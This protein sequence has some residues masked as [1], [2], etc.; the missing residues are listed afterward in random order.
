M[1]CRTFL[2]D[3]NLSFPV[4]SL[5][6]FAPEIAF[7]HKLILFFSLCSAFRS[8]FVV[9][10]D[11]IVYVSEKRAAN[12]RRMTTWSP[13]LT[14]R[15]A[16]ADNDTQACCLGPTLCNIVIWHFY[17]GWYNVDIPGPG[18]VYDLRTWHRC[19]HEQ[20]ETVHKQR[21]TQKIKKIKKNNFFKFK[22]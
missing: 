4:A 16:P 11:V 15:R 2:P 14:I 5:W 21:A 9:V 7:K 22:K 17:H 18:V 12:I 19:D 8:L 20:S 1:K 10:C 13:M 3:L 6:G